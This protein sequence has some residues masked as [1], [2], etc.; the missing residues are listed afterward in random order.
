MMRGNFRKKKQRTLSKEGLFLLRRPLLV[1]TP[2]DVHARVF[3]GNSTMVFDSP[4]H[5]HLL[6]QKKPW[7]MERYRQQLH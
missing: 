3:D 1:Q 6:S 5:L 2:M 4:K 7:T